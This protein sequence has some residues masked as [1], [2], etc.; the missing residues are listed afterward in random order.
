MKQVNKSKFL[1]YITYEIFIQT[2]ILLIIHKH[3]LIV[4]QIKTKHMQMKVL[5][6]NRL[7]SKKTH[8]NI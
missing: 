2:K 3:F 8:Y 5:K 1:L 4:I 6:N 7:V